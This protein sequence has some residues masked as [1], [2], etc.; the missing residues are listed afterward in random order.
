MLK[1]GGKMIMFKFFKKIFCSKKQYDLDSLNGIQNIPIPKYK[2]LNGM[3]DPSNNIE[4][5]LQKK[6]TEHKKNGRMDLAIACLRK[7]NEI[8][9]HSNFFWPEKDYMRLVEFLKQDRQFDEARKEKTKIEALFKEFE[10]E[11]KNRN[12]IIN[13]EIYG[14]IDVVETN[15]TA[16][17]CSECAKYT[18][19]RFSISGKNKKY[20]ILPKYLMEK[21]HEHKYCGIIVYPVLDNVSEPAWNYKGDFIK[22]C[23]RPFAD[24]RTNEQKELFDKEVREK[25][26]LAIDKEIYDIIFEKCPDIAPKSFG[27]YRRMKSANTSNY[28]K[29]LFEVEKRLGK[30]FNKR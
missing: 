13:Q 21:S 5:I 15:E 22:F 26:E 11:R 2:Q 4:Y 10:A 28:Q 9:P 14:E 16:F 24:E 27:G 17:V 20:P 1:D 18:K 6:A 3:G 23:N 8:F 7:A 25:E 29:L 30:N 19:R 12:D